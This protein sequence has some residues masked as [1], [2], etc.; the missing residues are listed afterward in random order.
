LNGNEKDEIESGFVPEQMVPPEQ[1][2]EM[3]PV[4]VSA[5]PESERPVPVRSLNDSPLTMRLV[6]LAIAK[7]AYVV[8]DAYPKERID[9]VADTPR[10]GCV[11]ASYDDTDVRYPLSLL[12]Q[13]SL[14]DDEAMVETTPFVPVKAKP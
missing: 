10:D 6:V 12:N 13:D 1:E 14:I 2:A 4:L 8:L 9:V 5:P 11:K 7:D 3:M